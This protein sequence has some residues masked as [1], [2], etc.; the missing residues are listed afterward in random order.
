MSSATLFLLYSVAGLIVTFFLVRLGV[1][2]YSY[3]KVRGK[4]LVTCPE[5]GKCAAVE[6]NAGKAA[7]EAF[8]TTPEFRLSACSRWPLKA[9]CGQ[10]CL[11]QIEL[12]PEE[13]LVRN[14]VLRW[15]EGKKCAL[16]G[17]VIREAEWLGHKP[18][19]MTPEKRTVYWDSIA[20][21]KLPEVFMTHAPIC[22]DCHITE[23]VRHDH[24]ERIVD[25]PWH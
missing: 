18:G 19:L 3:M 22:W 4:R 9:G 6:V 16:C 21:E 2:L 13:C 20:P 24:P 10:E 5:T 1:S 17:K 15:Y 23:T 14:Y 7:R 8:F 11:R 12:A 25:R